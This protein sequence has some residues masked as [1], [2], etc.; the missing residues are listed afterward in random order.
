MWSLTL[1]KGAFL[2]VFSMILYNMVCITI[3][4]LTVKFCGITPSCVGK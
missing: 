1:L 3:P 2:D 4:I